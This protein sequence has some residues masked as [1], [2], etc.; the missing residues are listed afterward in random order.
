V[1]HSIIFFFRVLFGYLRWPKISNT[2]VPDTSPPPQESAD[3]QNTS[4]ARL[5]ARIDASHQT[6]DT[7]LVSDEE[8]RNDAIEARQ[9]YR[10][11]ISFKL[12][13]NYSVTVAGETPVASSSATIRITVPS[14]CKHLGIDL[15]A[16]E[17]W[18]AQKPVQG[19]FWSADSTRAKPSADLI[20]SAK[21]C[22]DLEAF[23]RDIKN[24]LPGENKAEGDSAHLTITAHA[25][26]KVIDRA[27]EEGVI[28]RYNAKLPAEFDPILADVYAF[29]GDPL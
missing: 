14:S 16:H 13:S 25:L 6:D 4:K 29:L 9:E 22:R 5:K 15:Y 26:L 23:Y 19:G 21:N 3:T 7:P 11:L 1:F 18:P 24:W 17:H 28:D 8:F 20:E 12:P 2:P 27:L 10:S